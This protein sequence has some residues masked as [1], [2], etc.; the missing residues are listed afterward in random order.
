MSFGV[1]NRDSVTLLKTSGERIAGL[2][3]SVQGNRIYMGGRQ[4]LRIEQGDLILRTMS[5]GSEETYRVTDPGFFEGVSAMGPNYQMHVQKLLPSDAAS[6]IASAGE[7]KVSDERRDQLFAQWEDYGLDVI[8]GDLING[9][10]RYVGGPLATRALARA[11]VRMKEAERLQQAERAASHT[12]HVSGP[13][14]RV[15]LHSTDHSTNT[16]VSN[17]SVF[18]QLHEAVDTGVLEDGERTRL[19]TLIAEMEAAK[20]QKS[21]TAAYQAFI[22]SAANHMTILAP[23]LPALTHLITTFGA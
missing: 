15:N 1:L 12:I 11:W 5:N 3:A 6:A 23:M 18:N 13:N 16:V 9:G 7:D 22:A 14:A 20:D 4:G 17:N 2:K 10:F 19:K 21:F 8:K